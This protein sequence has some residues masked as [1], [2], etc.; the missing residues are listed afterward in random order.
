MGLVTITALGVGGA[1]M[2][3]AVIGMFLKRIPHK[4]TD[5]IIGFA[6]GVM[7]AASILGLILPAVEITGLR[8]LWQ[9]IAGV[10]ALSLIHI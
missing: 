5:G 1:T 10:L 7:L 2:I 9:V 8:G 4:W 6:A 3:G